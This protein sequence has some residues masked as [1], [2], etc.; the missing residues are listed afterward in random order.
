VFAAATSF[1]EADRGAGLDMSIPMGLIAW[2]ATIPH[3]QPIHPPGHAWT[4][5]PGRERG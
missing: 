3:I 2:I 4:P 5:A 1:S